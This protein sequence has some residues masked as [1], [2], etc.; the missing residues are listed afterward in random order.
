MK[1]NIL[2]KKMMGARRGVFD[3]FDL[4]L[5]AIF[6]LSLIPFML[7]FAANVSND[8]NADPQMRNIL[9]FIPII[10]ILLVVYGLYKKHQG[11]K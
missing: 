9:R 3:A 4:M 6:A 8:P 10:V 1:L 5:G 7:S 2:S 11:G